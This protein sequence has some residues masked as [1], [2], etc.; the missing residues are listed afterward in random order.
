MPVT[1]RAN[2]APADQKQRMLAR[3]F[4]NAFPQ[5][6]YGG[7]AGGAWNQF[8]G[9]GRTLAHKLRGMN[10][11]GMAGD[12]GGTLAD[13]LRGMNVGGMAGSLPNYPQPPKSPT[14]L[15]IYTP[16]PPPRPTGMGTQAQPEAVQPAPIPQTAPTAPQTAP[17][18]VQPVA[19]APSGR[20]AAPTAA[21]QGWSDIVGQTSGAVAGL[22]PTPQPLYNAQGVDSRGLDPENAKKANDYFQS[23]GEG[24]KYKGSLAAQHMLYQQY[25]QMLLRQ[26]NAP[27]ID[28][29][30]G[31]Q[32]GQYFDSARSRQ[33]AMDAAMG[34]S[35]GGVGAA[36]QSALY[37]RQ[38]SAVADMVRQLL[39]QRRQEQMAQEDFMRNMQAQVALKGLDRVYAKEDSP[40]FFQSLLPAIGSVAGSFLPIPGG[41]AIGGAVGGAL[42]GQS[43]RGYTGSD[44]Y[45]QQ[46]GASVGT[47]DP[48]FY[49]PYQDPNA[50]DAYGQYGQ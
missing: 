41:A 37:G 24:P 20:M 34:R 26:Q 18:A 22:A 49:G 5:G 10:V 45:G 21:P 23:L 33:T 39:E 6:T 43:S 50:L 9:T 1:T 2:A 17:V 44:P 28:Y 12:A 38:G 8:G 14:G 19:P 27:P 32:I 29:S 35:G 11:G 3:L 16:P 46:A 48:S 36:G 7:M 15:P 13:K 40:S 30:G 42:G 4:P 25:I 31:A 47:I